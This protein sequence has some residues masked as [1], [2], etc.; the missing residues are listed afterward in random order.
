M[1][2]RASDQ[3][4]QLRERP[5]PFVALAES[6]PREIAVLN[7][8][9]I[10]SMRSLGNADLDSIARDADIEPGQ[11]ESFRLQ[12][13]V[14]G[15]DEPAA[16]ALVNN[17]GITRRDELATTNAGAVFHGVN[18][19]EADPRF[20]EV[21]VTE[22]VA[23]AQGHDLSA[24]AEE[25]D[26]PSVLHDAGLVADK[27]LADSP[28]ATIVDPSDL[29]SPVPRMNAMAEAR[30]LMLEAGVTDLSTLGTYKFRSERVI[31]PGYHVAK[32]L[33]TE[34]NDLPTVSLEESLVQH[35]QKFKRVEMQ[36]DAIYFVQ[37][38]VTQAVIIGSVVEF[39]ENGE[40]VIGEEVTSL[41][42][43]AEEIRYS[44]VRKIRYEGNDLVPE[45]RAELN[46]ERA[47]DGV[48]DN[49]IFTYTPGSGDRGA[50]GGDGAHGRN[51]LVGFGGDRVGL[52]PTVTIYVKSTP[53]GLPE[54]DLVGHTGGLG[55]PGQGGGW[56]G[57][58]A[59]GRPGQSSI[60]CTR[61][62]GNGGNGGD[63]GNGGVGGPG[64]AGGP[65]GDLTVLTLADN[66]DTL[67]DGGPIGIDGGSGGKGGRGGTAGLPGFGGEPGEPK[68][69]C[70][71]KPER[72]GDDGEF[73]AFGIEGHGG[74]AGPGGTFTQQVITESDWNA[75]FTMP[76][77]IRLEPWDAY[78]DDILTVE[79]YNL[80]DDTIVLWEN[81]GE[82]PLALYE[83]TDVA[84]GT[85]SFR[86]PGGA[87]GLTSVQ[88][89]TTDALGQFAYSQELHVRILPRLDSITPTGG[90]PGT[91]VTLSGY[92]F[93]DGAVV[94]IG[95]RI[96]SAWSVAAT[97]ITLLLPD[98]SQIGLDE[99]E[100]DVV[101]V[102]PDGR[103]SDALTFDLSLTTRVRVKAWRVAPDSVL[104]GGGGFGD[105]SF[106]ARTESDIRALFRDSPTPQESWS[107]HNIEIT[108]D[109]VI[110]TIV[111]AADM[112]LL[113]P[114][115]PP[116]VEDAD[117]TETTDTLLAESGGEY[118]H[119]DED[120]VN[121]YFV[122]DI[123]GTFFGFG[124]PT[125]YAV[126]RDKPWYMTEKNDA[127]VVA[128]EL[129][130]VFGLSHVCDSRDPETSLSGR[131]CTKEFRDVD[132]QSLMYPSAGPGVREG[133]HIS[134]DEA[135]IAR[136]G[137]KD[138]HDG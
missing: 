78:V 109:P 91:F 69:F 88:L 17:A 123:E 29:L 52:A 83:E 82:L 15:L 30:A 90:V 129:G 80:T 60:A 5:D 70:S 85:I 46:P 71:A 27:V 134:P 66:V 37:N 76:W 130:H 72:R 112:A 61:S 136:N 65:G 24:H 11:L 114:Y 34:L 58:G 48:P 87:T 137:A 113:W 56:G 98:R 38:P 104:M 40:L 35:G 118:L 116:W 9:G 77:I 131:A 13:E 115:E 74:F 12:A 81:G 106:P 93:D 103:E 138:W 92:G 23:E 28:G 79:A 43:I 54:I 108:L 44:D 119:F 125:G 117:N 47:A 7:D 8:A 41:V 22:W 18:E 132:T 64:G 32:P 133:D 99:G 63:G 25:F 4:P 126:I 62:V 124:S 53:G 135:D 19:D 84:A 100:H 10:T 107:P 21:Q 68:G 59:K 26:R 16:S 110:E 1:P 127:L 45:P 2:V 49:V 20:N 75:A 39:L 128:H 50:K 111:V 6:R 67:L 122:T 73:G 105:P 3:R 89:R 51:G 121:I 120:A 14:P 94:R 42:I 96:F 55:G 102:N 57:N 86:I 97:D 33:K 95:S 36:Q 101:V 31:R